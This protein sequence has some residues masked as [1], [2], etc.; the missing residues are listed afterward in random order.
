MAQI[1]TKFITDAAVTNTKL[2]NMAT[3]TLKGNNTG[4][5]TAPLDLTV[6]QV[7]SML[8]IPT[9]GSPLPLNAG[10]TG[11]SAGSA[12]A[13]F[14]ALSPLTTK[15]DILSFSTVNARLGVGTDGQVLTADST[16][17]LGIKW[18]TPA[19]SGVTTIG[20]FNSQT[21]SANGLVISGTSLFA[22]AATAT[23]PGMISVPASASGLSLSTAA[24]SVAVDSSTTKINGSNQ[25]EALQP[26]EER[27]TL[28]GTD[29]TNQYVDLAHPIFGS[30]ASSNS[31]TLFVVGGPM[32]LKTVDYTVSLT[33]GGGG[34]T[35]ISFA[36]DLAT[37]GAAALVATDILVID[38]EYLA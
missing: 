19:S 9:S 31:A 11:V 21:S 30:N 20:T 38:Y 27:I 37:G 2:A 5:S 4:G 14:N 22:Q 29:I 25:V 28:S 3:L 1:K 17:T 35:R 10:G 8:S 18:A 23:N 26:A 33:G 13:A 16:Q 6:S 24:L 7:Q 36:G 32:Q 12:N 34:V 15:G